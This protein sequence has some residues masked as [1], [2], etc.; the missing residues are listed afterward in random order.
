MRHPD[1]L[2]VPSPNYGYPRGARGQLSRAVQ[3][4][5]RSGEFWHSMVGSLAA[6]KS[7]FVN[8]AEEVSAH[9]LFPRVGIPTQMV[10]SDDA[11]WHT[12]NYL[13]NLHFHG[14]EFEGG[15][16]GNL[17]EPLT[18]NQI[19][20]GVKITRWLRDGRPK[21]YVRRE[22]LWEH[23]EV[24]AT[25]CPSG[26][27]PW[28][29]VISSLEDGMDEAAVRKM[30]EDAI[31]AMTDGPGNCVGTDHRIIQ[32]ATL[33]ACRAMLEV[34]IKAGLVI[35][36]IGLPDH[37]S[38]DHESGIVRQCYQPTDHDKKLGLFAIG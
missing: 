31:L 16:P 30:I 14:V 35:E 1:C 20:W 19:D 22:T 24:K 7:R 17:S 12:G 13:A 5:N 10:D 9:F 6:A 21:I 37:L 23:N 33:A 3:E 25:A 2:W 29:R 36:L 26:R 28:A 32:T 38:V 11:A 18:D 15:A 8:P 4:A 27:I 34:R